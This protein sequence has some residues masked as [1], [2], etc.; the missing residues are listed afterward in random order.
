MAIRKFIKLY[1]IHDS[2]I[3]DKG[4]V[5]PDAALYP[6][7]D[8]YED[9]KTGME[10]HDLL[11]N[12]IDDKLS[13]TDREYD[14]SSNSYPD[15]VVHFLG[16][17]D[18]TIAE[19]GP[20][21]K[22][23][24]SVLAY[25]NPEKR[26]G[27]DYFDDWHYDVKANKDA[28]V[29]IARHITPDEFDRRVHNSDFSYGTYSTPEGDIGFI[30][31]PKMFTKE[32]SIYRVPLIVEADDNDIINYN[33][34]VKDNYDP[35]R[36][37][38]PEVQLKNIIR[39]SVMP[40]T[41]TT[42]TQAVAKQNMSS[43]LAILADNLFKYISEAP[44]KFITDNNN[45]SIQEVK[46]IAISAIDGSRAQLYEFLTAVK[47]AFELVH[48]SE[49]NSALEQ[50]KRLVSDTYTFS[51]DIAVTTDTLACTQAVTKYF[52]HAKSICDT[53]VPLLLDQITRILTT[54]SAD[55]SHVLKQIN[56]DILKN[57]TQKGGA[58]DWYDRSTYSD[59][60]LKDIYSGCRDVTL[61]DKQLKY[62]Y[63][64]FRKFKK[65]AT[66]NNI[67]KGLRGL[68]Q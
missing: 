2:D 49:K 45:K 34:I 10:Y 41:F 27:D 4:N 16:S 53:Y 7:Y 6:Y 63:D 17:D 9:P 26:H 61:S 20:N 15:R 22:R 62:I 59:E 35:T 8:D 33:D 51:F 11:P 14:N 32:D 57:A 43:E 23:G 60:R 47:R 30:T 39:K 54:A 18:S 65:G 58:F 21:L 3:D 38:V 24:Y 40:N 55:D 42:Q 44:K 68:G 66:Q 31:N 46:Q 37:Y 13:D 48:S 28:D 52:N 64:D 29:H 50:L 56:S 5:N 19:V 67:T 36:D 25:S 12:Q 1:G